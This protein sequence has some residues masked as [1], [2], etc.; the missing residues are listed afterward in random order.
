MMRLFINF[1]LTGFALD[2][3]VSV[4]DDFF[5]LL[6]GEHAM[7]ALRELLALAVFGLSIIVYLAL[8]I[9]S[10]LP[11][12][13][14]LPLTLF[15]A[16][17]TFGC[18]P[19]SIYIESPALLLGASLFQ[20]ALAAFAFLYVRKRSGGWLLPEDYFARPVLRLK[21]TLLFALGN[22]VLVPAAAALL[23][24]S[25]AYA[26]MDHKTAGFMRIGMD[27][28][29]L[30]QRDYQ[31][32]G[33]TVRL[34]PMVHIAGADY[35]RELGEMLSSGEAVVLAEGVSD[36]EG[37]MKTGLSYSKVADF[38]GLASQENMELRGTPLDYEDLDAGAAADAAGPGIVRADID[39]SELS[40]ETRRYIETVGRLFNPQDSFAESFRKYL[41]WYEENMTPEKEKA[42]FSEIIDKRNET[43]LRYLD[44][45][46]LG[47][48]EIAVPWGA[49]HM[50]GLE[51]A[52]LDRDFTLAAT[53]TKR[54]VDFKE[55]FKQ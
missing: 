10:R 28:I 36:R 9:D 31:R 45:A 51:R 44:R 22:I 42:V 14:L 55:L 52:L 40:E 18:L 1:F 11:K 38:I 23:L 13:M 12:R 27:G 50:P 25:S 41:S 24:A 53:R 17:A 37:L 30:E 54:A 4:V 32:D 33:K 6:S 47:H 43:L 8:G 29:H 46:L 15:V 34:I 26:Y 20:L 39:S 21:N 35:Y 48:D 5:F 16:W 3:A 19:L 2:A 7:G 49:L